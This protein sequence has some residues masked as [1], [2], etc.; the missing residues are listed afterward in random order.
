LN[1]FV[2]TAGVALILRFGI[3]GALISEVATALLAAALT[4]RAYAS[5]LRPRS[6]HSAAHNS[7][8]VTRSFQT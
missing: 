8:A 2:L 3:V 7:F 4:V 1:A 6:G 5:L